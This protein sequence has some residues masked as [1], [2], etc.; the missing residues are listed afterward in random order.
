VDRNGVQ[1]ASRCRDSSRGHRGIELGDLRRPP[2][3][4][5]LAAM[6]AIA[7]GV[8]QRFAGIVGTSALLASGVCC[9]ERPVMQL[10]PNQELLAQRLRDGTPRERR[11]AINQVYNVLPTDLTGSLRRA[12]VD[13]LER[14][15]ASVLAQQRLAAPSTSATDP[16]YLLDLVYV[17]SRLD[18][19]TAS[20]GLAQAVHTGGY[21]ITALANLG[22][23]AFA[24][25]LAVA[26]DRG[27]PATSRS[28]AV[29]ALQEMVQVP[30]RR[31]LSAASKARL[32]GLAISL[33]SERPNNPVVLRA[34]LD[35]SFFVLSAP[36][37]Q[38]LEQLGLSS[39]SVRALGISDAQSV[40]R[41]RNQA[42]DRRKGV[43]PPLRPRG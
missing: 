35:M 2:L 20:R 34:A 21:A 11:S 37:Q 24:H 6:S 18:D 32:Q 27:Q 30:G 36:V 42:S 13:E 41:L 22:E 17:V 4:R 38:R 33:L 23:S 31:P 7:A 3:A 12:L 19:P 1:P 15:A 29:I 14:E 9:Q 28:A 26:S 39:D 40:D 16:E 5:W 10:K 43:K 25:V 8:A